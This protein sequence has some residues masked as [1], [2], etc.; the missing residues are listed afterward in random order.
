MLQKYFHRACVVVTVITAGVTIL[1]LIAYRSRTGSSR[2]EPHSLDPQLL[3]QD[4]S[5]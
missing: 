2:L 3:L 1:L 4:L 5:H